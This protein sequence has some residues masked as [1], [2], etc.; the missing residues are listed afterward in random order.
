[1][2]FIGRI[3]FL[4]GKI[5]NASSPLGYALGFLAFSTTPLAAGPE[6]TGGLTPA[7]RAAVLNF[8]GPETE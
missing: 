4:D 1:M 6:G 5:L 8:H 2:E 7:V 3:W